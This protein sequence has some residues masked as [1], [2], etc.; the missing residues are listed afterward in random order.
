[1]LHSITVT[2]YIQ[3][4]CL[5]SIGESALHLAI[6]NGDLQAVKFLV[7]KGADV[8]QKAETNLTR[9][10]KTGEGLLD[11]YRGIVNIKSY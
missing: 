1:M 7:S 2:T 10:N 11:K 5:P 3:Q 9:A 8:N 4:N 6:V